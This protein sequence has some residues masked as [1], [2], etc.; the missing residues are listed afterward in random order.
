[1]LSSTVMAFDKPHSESH[2]GAVSSYFFAI[3]APAIVCIATAPNAL[4]CI[5]LANLMCLAITFLVGM[6][7]RTRSFQDPIIGVFI[8]CVSSMA[9]I[10]YE[11]SVTSGTLAF[12]YIPGGDGEGYFRD[13]LFIGQDIEWNLPQVS[14]NYRGYQVILALIF[15]VFGES[16]IVGL[17]FNYIVLVVSALLISGFSSEAT[18]DTRVGKYTLIACCLSTHFFAQGTIL[19]KDVLIIFAFSLFA[20]SVL[21]IS[22]NGVRNPIH[23]VTLFLSIVIVGIT[24]LPFAL[25]FFVFLLLS[26]LFQAQTGTKGRLWQSAVTLFAVATTFAILPLL[27]RFTTNEFNSESISGMA[28]DDSKIAS[29][30]EETSKTGVVGRISSLYAGKGIEIRVMLA[31]LPVIVQYL[32]PFAFTSSLFLEDHPWYFIN[33]QLGIIWLFVLG[34]SAVFAFLDM[35]RLSNRWIKTSLATGVIAYALVAFSYMG[36]IP[37]YATPSLALIFPAVGY[38]WAR[39]FTDKELEL[40][41]AAWMQRYWIA[42]ILIATLYFCLRGSL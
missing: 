28:L 2:F 38:V 34:P 4:V 37:R 18:N 29:L 35:R 23:L 5:V 21:K 10:C 25:F 22:T 19:Q 31:P 33:N 17:C 8:A 1:M 24:R 14:T 7:V 15:S 32:L 42:G 9:L 13:A 20:F 12:P 36:V 40:R 16:L 27:M 11:S 41:Y 6:H 26:V 39:R 30:I 3:I